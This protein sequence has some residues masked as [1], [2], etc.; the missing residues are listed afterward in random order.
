MAEYTC[1]CCVNILPTWA[2]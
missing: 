1:F 2:P